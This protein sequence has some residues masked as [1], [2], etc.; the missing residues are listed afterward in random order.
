[1]STYNY[2]CL[3]PQ[4]ALTTGVV[5][6]MQTLEEIIFTD[7][8]GIYNEYGV[9]RRE[10]EEKLKQIPIEE[11]AEALFQNR[12]EAVRYTRKKGTE[13][14]KLCGVMSKKGVDKAEHESSEIK[15][16]NNSFMDQLGQF[17]VKNLKTKQVKEGW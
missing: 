2:L 1:M 3:S 17:D 8:M 14:Y 5:V 12:K 11:R 4:E 10:D 7:D 13:N 16:E 9:I 15:Q 6:G